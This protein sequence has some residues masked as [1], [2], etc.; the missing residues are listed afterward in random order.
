M[1][2]KFEEKLSGGDLRSIGKVDL[3]VN[4]IQSQSDFDKL[5][6]CLGTEDRLIVM[7][8]ADAIEKITVKHADFLCS[9]KEEILEFCKCADNI[10]F[11]WHLALLLSRLP[12]TESECA[13]VLEILSS[14]LR[15]PKESKI[16]RVNSMQALYELFRK[17]SMAEQKLESILSE[18]EKENVPSLLARIRRIRSK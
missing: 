4:E 12:L 5:F 13:G 3:I 10:E 17:G 11:K 9:H 1:R 7:R 14:W 6:S 18:V 8:A 15:D 2:D 16:V